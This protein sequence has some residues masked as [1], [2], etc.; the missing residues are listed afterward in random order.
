MGHYTK[1]AI[2]FIRAFGVTAIVYAA[3]MLVWFVTASALR[4]GGPERGAERGLGMIGWLVYLVCSI[5]LLIFAQ[6]LGKYASRGLEEVRSSPP[7]V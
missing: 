4:L 3:S 6:P 2:L 7:T 1:L 5:V